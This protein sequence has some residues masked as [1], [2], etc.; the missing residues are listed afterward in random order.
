MKESEFGRG[1]VTCLVKFAEHFGRSALNFDNDKIGGIEES[2]SVE[3]W[4][5]GASDHLYEITV[6]KKW[7]DTELERK[8]LELKE[9][10]LEMGHGFTGKKWVKQ[11]IYNLGYLAEE[12]A[13][14]IDG[15]IGLKRIVDRGQW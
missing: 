8:V 3:V 12:I 1:L 9:K 6:P 11:D 14:M 10:G 13:V 5:N 7:K 4:A 15:K 2:H